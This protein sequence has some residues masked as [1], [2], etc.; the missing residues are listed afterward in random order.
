MLGSN[1]VKHRFFIKSK[2]QQLQIQLVVVGCLMLLITL[3]A[4]FSWATKLY[5]I[6]IIAASISLTVVAPFI[7]VPAMKQKGNLIYHSPLFVSE[8]PRN[9]VVKIH[10][11]S[12]FD[13]VFV[14]ESKMNGNQ[15]TNLILQQFLEGLLHLIESNKNDRDELTIRGTSYIIN[16]RTA[17]KMGFR[18]VKTDPIQKLILIFNYINVMITYSIAKKKISFPNIN[19]TITFECKLNELI[20]HQDFIDNLNTKLKKLKT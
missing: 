15:R 20:Q 3:A 1:S 16:E 10:G 17:N 13:Y 9:G 11:G 18:V 12:L 19:H 4:L 7:D 6:G 2:K 8:K 14:L 5:F